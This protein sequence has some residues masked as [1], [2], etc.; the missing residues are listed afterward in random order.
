MSVWCCDQIPYNWILKGLGLN[1]NWK[2][3]TPRLLNSSSLGR[4]KNKKKSNS[5]FLADSVKFQDGEIDTPLYPN[6]SWFMFSKFSF[7]RMEE[8][9]LKKIF[10]FYGLKNCIIS[11]D[12]ETRMATWVPN[13]AFSEEMKESQT[14]LNG[15]SNL[16]SQSILNKK[17]KPPIV[18]LHG[19]G[20][21]GIW[22]WAKQISVLSEKFEIF[23]PDLIFFGES[24]S[25]K[26]DRSEIFQA[27]CVL[28]LMDSFGIQ[29]FDIAGI[30]YGG[31]VA[32]RIA[33]L[34][35]ARVR[36][37]ILVD[38]GIMVRPNEHKKMLKRWKVENVKKL[39]LPETSEG[40]W[41]LN[42][43]SYYKP[44]PI[45]HF[46]LRDALEVMFRTR[47]EEKKE[48]LDELEKYVHNPPD[49]YPIP[50]QEILI[51]W[52]ENDEIFPVSIA[53]RMHEHFGA[54]S[55]LVV[56]KKSCHFVNSE[57]PQEFNSALINFL[58]DSSPPY[59]F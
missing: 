48:L 35:A 33:T 27:E 44:W 43:V 1:T 42:E 38:S 30:S 46:I 47:V 45:P 16:S 37:L 6:N 59:I 31:F 55:R 24:S 26:K 14:G 54:R 51:V 32:Y 11:I 15:D 58:E 7:V 39:L 21:S 10:E 18:L 13:N 41:K 8:M 4:Y 57:K 50:E 9:R 40:V 52:G 2:N 36:K 25:E 49:P 28:K 23:M 3:G 19:F 22:Q 17:R 53:E 20:A 12:S 5:K 29:K 56:I 34:Q